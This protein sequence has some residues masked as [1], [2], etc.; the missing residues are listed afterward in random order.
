M[1]SAERFYDD[2]LA[3]FVRWAEGNDEVRAAFVVGSRARTEY[4]ADDYSDLD[5]VFFCLNQGTYISSLTWPHE[6]GT[7]WAMI[8]NQ[9]L[10]GDPELQIIYEGGYQVD[11]VIHSAD[12]LRQMVVRKYCPTDFLRGAKYIIDKDGVSEYILPLNAI[13]PPNKPM[14]EELF[15]RA[16]NEFWFTA[17][18][19]AKLILRN[20]LWVAK[21]R[22]AE[23]K[24]LLLQIIEW[25]ERAM[26]GAEQIIWDAGRYIGLWAS[27]DIVTELKS[28]YGHYDK[29]DSWNALLATMRMFRRLSL[30]LASLMNFTYCTDIED[31][32]TTW[33]IDSHSAVNIHQPEVEA[34]YPSQDT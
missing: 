30:E 22:D 16:V 24:A 3:R 13:A 31:K 4:P 33:I 19:T 27:A 2:F 15:G 6:F 26:N 18:T 7:V 8:A 34:A 10:G 32:V 1:T 25:H 23:L 21:N 9:K 11:F 5:I 14:T 28:V 20:G 17:I 29:E 12:V